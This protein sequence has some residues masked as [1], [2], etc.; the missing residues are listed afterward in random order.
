LFAGCSLIVQLLLAQ[1]IPLPLILTGLTLILG[2]TAEISSSARAAAARLAYR[3][4][5]H[6][7]SR[8]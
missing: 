5:F 6:T 7:Q 4:Y 2:V 8:W 3:G 1:T